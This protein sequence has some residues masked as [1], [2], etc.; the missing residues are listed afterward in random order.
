M[1]QNFLFEAEIYFTVCIYLILFIHSSIDGLLSCFC[2]LPIENNAAVNL[3]SPL[4]SQATEQ[5]HTDALGGLGMGVVQ[6]A[7]LSAQNM[8]MKAL[9]LVVIY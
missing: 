4:G 5:K 1:G 7:A 3:L 8:L 9:G 2:A 6:G